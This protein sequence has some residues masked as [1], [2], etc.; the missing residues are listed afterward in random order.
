MYSTIWGATLETPANALRILNQRIVQLRRALGNMLIPILIKV[1]PYVQAFVQ[2]LT[3]VANKV[4]T[5]LGFELTKIDYDRRMVND[6][7]DL[8][9]AFGDVNEEVAKFKNAMAGIDE[10]NILGKPKQ[11]ALAAGLGGSDLDIKLPSIDDWLDK[12]VDK[13]TEILQ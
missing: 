8:G 3:D 6:I 10:I 13:G 1:I 12:V 5:L 2:V 11:G 4:A 7:I 9:D